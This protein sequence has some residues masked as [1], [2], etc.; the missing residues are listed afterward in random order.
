[1]VET[2][3]AV[4]AVVVGKVVAAVRPVDSVLDSVQRKV[5]VVV[6]RAAAP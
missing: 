6:T 2:V 3:A 5:V 1:M 4:A